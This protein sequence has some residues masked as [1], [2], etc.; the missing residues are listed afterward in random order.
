LNIEDL[1][2][3][4]EREVPRNERHRQYTSWRNKKLQIPR[5]ENAKKPLTAEDAKDAE[6]HRGMRII[7]TM[8]I[9][10]LRVLCVL[11]G[12]EVLYFFTPSAL[13]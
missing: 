5:C 8:D 1:H 13:G 11:R 3:D 10:S 7:K 4:L 2:D 12:E 6:V 9:D